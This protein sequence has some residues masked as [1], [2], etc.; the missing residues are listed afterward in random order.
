MSRALC[1]L[2]LLALTACINPLELGE[3][4]YREG[5]R[6]AALESWR[7]VRSDSLYYEA[8]QR[9]IRDVEDELEQLV[10]LVTHCPLLQ[11]LPTDV[12][13][14]Q[15]CPPVPQMLLSCSA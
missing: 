12:Q 10:V 4:R 6:L 8:V 1:L 7:S 13:S 14:R 9:R 5:D 11:T 2:L 3:R 15:V